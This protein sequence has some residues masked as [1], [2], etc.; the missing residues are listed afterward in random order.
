MVFITICVFVAGGSVEVFSQV[1]PCGAVNNSNSVSIRAFDN[2]EESPRILGNPPIVFP[3][4][5]RYKPI[6]GT[7]SLKV[8]FLASRK[9]GKIS[10][11]KGLQRDLD[12]AVVKAARKIKFVPAKKNGRRVTVA[13]IVDYD[14]YDRRKCLPIDKQE[15]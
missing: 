6:I 14:F 15:N 3:P 11:V 5:L 7:V 8:T 1:T 4:A 2:P 9:I 12:T 13:K 10:V